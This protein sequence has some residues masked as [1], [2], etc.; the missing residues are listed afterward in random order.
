MRVVVRALPKKIQIAKRKPNSLPAPDIW[1]RDVALWQDTRVFAYCELVA[2]QLLML[3]GEM[4]QRG[5]TT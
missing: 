2:R 5:Q 3:W 1:T 4:G